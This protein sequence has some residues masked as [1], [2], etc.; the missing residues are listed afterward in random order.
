MVKPAARR[1]AATYF[2]E[3]FGVSQQR[4]CAMATLHRSTY[5]YRGQVR[6]E[7]GALRQRLREQNAFVESFN[8]RFRDECLNQ[9]WFTSLGDARGQIGAWR[10][11]YNAR[12]PHSAR[13]AHAHRVCRF[14]P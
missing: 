6:A 1:E 11:D 8:G 13:S 5:A 2:R 3:E 14:D 7:A 4:A 12:R 9:H 10:D